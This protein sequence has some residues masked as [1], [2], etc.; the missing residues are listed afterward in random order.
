MAFIKV[1][2]E[3]SVII[4]RNMATHARPMLSND[5]VPWKGLFPSCV[6]FV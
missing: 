1:K 5:I 3:K 6:Q 4:T 2:E